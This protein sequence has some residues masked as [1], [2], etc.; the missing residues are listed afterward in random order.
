MSVHCQLAE[1]FEGIWFERVKPLSLYKVKKGEYP[2]ADRGVRPQ[3]IKHMHMYN[4]RKL[5]ELPYHL[6]KSHQFEKFRN[7][8]GT[9]FEFLQ[10]VVCAFSVF[11]AITMLKLALQTM[12]F[13]GEIDS[14]QLYQDLENVHKILILSSEN[15]SR[16]RNNLA[17]EVMETVP[18]AFLA[19]HSKN[20]LSA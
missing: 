4:E 19:D 9:N 17:V 18:Y 5:S 20:L 8:C 12:D 7:L 16:D 13:A 3:M 2:N 11:E 1:Y 14:P 6:I 15:I 10:G